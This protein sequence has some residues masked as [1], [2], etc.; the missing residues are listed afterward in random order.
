[1]FPLAQRQITTLI[2]L[3]SRSNLSDG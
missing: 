3:W 1:V 2:D